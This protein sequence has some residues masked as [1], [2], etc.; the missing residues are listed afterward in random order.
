MRY[1]NQKK[2]TNI[3]ISIAFLG[4]IILKEKT[5]LFWQFNVNKCLSNSKQKRFSFGCFIFFFNKLILMLKILKI[6]KIF[7]FFFCQIFNT[8]RV[9]EIFIWNP[10][11]RKQFNNEVYYFLILFRWRIAAKKTSFFFS[12]FLI[13]TKLFER[14]ERRIFDLNNLDLNYH[15]PHSRSVA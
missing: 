9:V 12:F 6:V 3:L 8:E 13:L 5:L 7:F 4:L 2:Q 11:F 15:T 1:I 14:F 10:Y